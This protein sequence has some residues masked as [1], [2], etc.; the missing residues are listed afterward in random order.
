MKELKCKYCGKG[1][2]DDDF[3]SWYNMECCL[4][5]YYKGEDCNDI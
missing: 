1:K 2:E 5:C 3:K 4:A